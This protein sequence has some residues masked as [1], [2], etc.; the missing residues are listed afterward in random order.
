[1]NITHAITRISAFALLGIIGFSGSA[2]EAGNY[3]CPASINIGVTSNLDGWAGPSTGLRRSGLSQTTDHAGRVKLNCH[4]G[5]YKLTRFAG[6]NK[7]CRKKPD[8]FVCNSI[9]AS[10]EPAAN[11][12]AT[13]TNGRLRWVANQGVDM[14]RGQVGNPGG[15]DFVSTA[16]SIVAKGRVRFS[17]LVQSGTY[18]SCAAAQ[19]NKREIRMRD[20]QAGSRFCLTTDDGRVS[21]VVVHSFGE[22]TMNV[23]Y[24]TWANN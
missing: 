18:A 15:A 6:T 19:K 4:Y 11:A 12:P 8:G 21:S 9:Q 24:R 3:T 10:A 1:M 5:E 7:K 23:A 2:A 20:L 16:N 13:Y 22:G 17:R 14:D